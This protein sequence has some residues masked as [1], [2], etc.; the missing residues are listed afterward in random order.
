MAEILNTQ[1]VYDEIKTKLKESFAKLSKSRKITLASVSV[2]EDYS[3]GV[4][5]SSQR[6]LAA[7]LGVEYLSVNLDKNISFDDFAKKVQELNSNPAVTGIILT[8]PFPSGW[9]EG[10]AFGLIDQHKDVEGVNPYNL[11]L[12]LFKDG[13]AEFI[14]PTVLSILKFLEMSK[15]PLASKE[16]VIVGASLLIG[17]PLSIILTNQGATVTL[18]HILTKDLESHIKKADLIISAVGKPHMIK[19]SWIKKGAVIVDVGTGKKDGK[20]CGDLEFEAAKERAAFITPV[21]GGVGK[22]TPLF[23]FKNL[24]LAATIK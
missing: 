1:I 6:K 16:A 8:K 11:G 13:V 5:M 24:E 7:E 14:S 4:Y 10:R 17:K 15:E 20:I 9:V 23:L 21:P 2:G 22:L 3:A 19:G 18:T 12:L